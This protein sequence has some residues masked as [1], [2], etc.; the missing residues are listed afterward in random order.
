MVS[1]LNNTTDPG[2]VFIITVK[3]DIKKPVMSTGFLVLMM[4]LLIG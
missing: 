3:T 2:N 4:Y 1:V